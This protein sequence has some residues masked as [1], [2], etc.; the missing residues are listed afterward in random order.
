MYSVIYKDTK[1]INHLESILHEIESKAKS[2][3]LREMVPVFLGLLGIYNLKGRGLRAI[4]KPVILFVSL[5]AGVVKAARA[6]KLAV[7]AELNEMNSTQNQ[8]EENII[9]VSL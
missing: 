7:A 3:K 4:L 2:D 1:L 5:F 8:L 9:R 6:T